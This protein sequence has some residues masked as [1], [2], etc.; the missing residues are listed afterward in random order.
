MRAAKSFLC[1][2]VRPNEGWPFVSDPRYATR[3]SNEH[4]VLHRLRALESRSTCKTL[5]ARVCETRAARVRR[6]LRDGTARGIS[7]RMRGGGDRWVHAVR[8]G[9]AGASETA[10]RVLRF[11]LVGASGFAIDVALYLAL[12]W[13]GL[14]HRVARFVA[15]FPA[16]S[17]NWLLNRR[18]TFSERAPDARARQWARF[19]TSSLAGAGV[20]AGSYAALTSLTS[21]FDQHRVLA[22]LLG[23]GIG[24]GVNFA[25]ATRYVYRRRVADAS[26]TGPSATPSWSKRCLAWI[27]QQFLMRQRRVVEDAHRHGPVHSGVEFNRHQDEARR[28]RRRTHHTR[29]VQGQWLLLE[30]KAVKTAILGWGSLL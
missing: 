14:D 30:V 23:I 4:R 10:A 19:V 7:R 25:L 13:A 28:S 26:R 15:F 27:A 11:G 9:C 20:N 29:S 2:P 5:P 18:V 16:A 17:W 12:Q 21:F 8:S 3:E 6:W 22:L 1:P 24:G